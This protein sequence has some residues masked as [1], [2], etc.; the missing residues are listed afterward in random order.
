MR[1]LLAA[2][3]M[4]LV[5]VAPAEASEV[6]DMRVWGG[7][8][9]TRVVFDLTGPLEHS[10]FSLEDPHRLVIDLRNA[11]AVTRLGSV[12]DEQDR[13]RRVRS[14]VR[15]GTDLRLVLDLNRELKPSTFLLPPTGPHGH[16][17]VVDL[18]DRESGSRGNREARRAVRSAGDRDGTRPRDLVIAIDAGHG[19]EDPGAIGYHGTHEKE[20]V[21]AISRRLA[22]LVDDE[23]GMRA[24][25]TRDGDYYISLRQRSAKAREQHA[26][27]FISI[28]ADAFRNP[29]AH[30]SSVY[31]LSQSGASDEAA[32][33]LANRENAA[34]RIGGVDLHDKD[35]QLASVL[36]DLSQ[37]ATLDA[38]FELG[39]KIIG[40][41]SSL[42]PVHRGQ[43]QQAPFA[44]LKSPDLPSILVE[45]AFIS[46]PEEERRLK[47]G[48][49]QQALARALL[50]GIKG[51]F[52]ERL[53]EHGLMAGGP[54]EH[55]IQ[56]GETLSHIASRYQTS[57]AQLRHFNQLE[58][59][60]VR[61][62]EILRIP[63]SG[64]S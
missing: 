30:G 12:S 21:L 7:P 38:S 24:L 45:T 19:G 14:G 40:E 2:A 1:G 10:V 18:H 39:E 41:L 64:D 9:H 55:V 31:V 11:R 57:V 17:L 3:L 22:R 4:M 53:P 25:L 59:D 58:S 32:R 44:V 8:E 6:T 27:L 50:R 37:T 62:G 28:H 20:V 35:D 16:R 34:D 15:D 13:V 5:F 33:W 42:G 46:N 23:P 26:D 56:R 60:R 43:V 61:A 54:V 51:Y 49:H 63:V 29:Q 52:R 48:R 47:D 36:L